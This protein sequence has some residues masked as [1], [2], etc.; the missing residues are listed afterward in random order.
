MQESPRRGLPELKLSRRTNFVT[1]SLPETARHGSRTDR[2]PR[3][4]RVGSSSLLP[5]R[6]L[7][8]TSPRRYRCRTP[9]DPVGNPCYECHSGTPDR[10]LEA[11]AVLVEQC[12]NGRWIFR[13]EPSDSNVL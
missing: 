4:R 11:L 2:V 5:A 9:L 1:A 7:F 8:P 12:S 10:I 13:G 3:N 6:S